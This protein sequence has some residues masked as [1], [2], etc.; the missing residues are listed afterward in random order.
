[1]KSSGGSWDNADRVGTSREKQMVKDLGNMQAWHVSNSSLSGAM[2]GLVFNDDCASQEQGK[3]TRKPRNRSNPNH[4]L[5]FEKS[6]VGQK[7]EGTIK[8]T[9]S[10]L[11]QKTNR[12]NTLEWE[13]VLGIKGSLTLKFS[14]RIWRRKRNLRRIQTS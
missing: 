7:G 6:C 9:W 1:M 5:S 2:K 10:R 12:I 11:S 3:R 4:E 8:H 14:M 13:D